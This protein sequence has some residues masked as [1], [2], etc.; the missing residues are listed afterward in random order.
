M[1]IFIKAVFDVTYGVAERSGEGNGERARTP[2]RE[3][4]GE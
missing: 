1:S 2:S 4:A 3:G